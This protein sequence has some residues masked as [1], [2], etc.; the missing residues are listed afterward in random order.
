MPRDE[1]HPLGG[2]GEN[3][4]LLGRSEP[5]RLPNSHTMVALLPSQ[6][7]SRLSTP[8][9]NATRGQYPSRPDSSGYTG[10]GPLN[11]V[12]PF[13]FYPDHNSTSCLNNSMSRPDTAPPLHALALGLTESNTS[14]L[15][16]YAKRAPSRGRPMP[17][18]ALGLPYELPSLAAAKPTPASRLGLP[19]VE[20]QRV[21]VK[22]NRALE[23]ALKRMGEELGRLRELETASVHEASRLR[24]E[25]ETRLEE[26]RL[27]TGAAGT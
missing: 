19:Y 1:W 23:T 3:G 15:A 6:A 2:L 21:L 11:P 17:A 25:L 7:S 10:P 20:E 22:R 4:T 14:S 27:R 24:E 18:H 13:D 26:V 5:T 8:G 16:G 12:A 9:T